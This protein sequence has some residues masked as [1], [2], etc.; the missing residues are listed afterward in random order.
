M[1][2]VFDLITVITLHDVSD[3]GMEVEILVNWNNS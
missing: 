1:Y 3:T 2:F